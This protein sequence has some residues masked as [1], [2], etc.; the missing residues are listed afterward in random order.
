MSEF[1]WRAPKAYANMHRADRPGMAWECVRRSPNYR[2][3]YS[4]TVRADRD[5]A[6][7][8]R[9]RWGLIFRT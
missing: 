8:F 4:A 6:A 1:D 5:D 2:A 9:R 7:T 3:Q